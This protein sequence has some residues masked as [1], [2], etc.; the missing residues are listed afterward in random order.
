ML[1]LIKALEEIRLD[2][3]D[4][5][6]FDFFWDTAICFTGDLLLFVVVEDHLLREILVVV[7]DIDGLFNFKILVDWRLF[8]R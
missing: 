5:E 1:N 6:S 4:V 2:L 3:L 8:I 7:V